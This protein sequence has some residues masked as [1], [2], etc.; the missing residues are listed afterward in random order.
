M[1]IPDTINFHIICNLSFFL[2]AWKADQM[3]QGSIVISDV[4]SNSQKTVT[5]TTIKDLHHSTSQDVLQLFLA[6]YLEPAQMNTKISCNN[7]QCPPPPPPTNP[8]GKFY[9]SAEAN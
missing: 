1:I 8:P 4:E 6:A 2:L 3:S 7:L 5:H 9:L